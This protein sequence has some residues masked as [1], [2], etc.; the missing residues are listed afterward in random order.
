MAYKLDLPLTLGFHLVFHV[1]FLKVEIGQ[2][3]FLIPTLPL[4]DAHDHLTPKPKAILQQ[5]P[6]QL[7]RYKDATKVLVHWESSSPSDATWEI[8][9]KL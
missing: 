6:C 1:S 2:I 8:L 4:V 3:F 5:R 9:H 7:Q